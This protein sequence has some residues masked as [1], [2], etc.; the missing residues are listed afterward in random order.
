MLRRRRHRPTVTDANLLLG[1][2]DADYFLGGRMTLDRTAAERA[3]APLAETLGMS[4]EAT[5]VGIHRVVNESMISA[6]RVH[7]A[8]RGVDPRTVM[9]MAFGGAG[10]AH[11]DAI[12]RSLK[13]RGYIIPTT[14]GV[15]SALG[16][17]TAP[18]AF[19]LARIRRAW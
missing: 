18:I 14:A 3:V 2:L 10:P 1:Y 4:V 12:A 15:A 17:L 6:T 9:L 13:M 5:A 11:A 8:E 19:D 16:F 7:I